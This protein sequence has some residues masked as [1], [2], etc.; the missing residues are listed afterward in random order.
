MHYYM[1]LEQ[2]EKPTLQQDPTGTYF[3]TIPKRVVEALNLSVGDVFVPGKSLDNTTDEARWNLILR[4]L[5]NT[6]GQ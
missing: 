5:N 4:H 2:D 3:I 1:S 6:S